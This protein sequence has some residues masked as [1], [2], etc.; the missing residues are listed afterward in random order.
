MVVFNLATSRPKIEL[1]LA[2][3]G[4]GFLETRKLSVAAGP[5]SRLA[6]LPLVLA[7]CLDDR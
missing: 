3:F 5:R 6:Q 1:A 2:S 7:P 4:L